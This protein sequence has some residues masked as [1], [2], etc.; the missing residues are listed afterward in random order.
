M[1]RRQNKSC[2]EG[3]E[4]QLDSFPM[5]GV[6]GNGIPQIVQNE[7]VSALVG[8]RPYLSLRNFLVD[9]VMPG[10]TGEAIRFL[11]HSMR[12]HADSQRR[13]DEGK[14]KETVKI[15]L[16][17]F[18]HRVIDHN[19]VSWARCGFSLSE[20][21]HPCLS[22]TRDQQIQAARDAMPPMKE[23]DKESSVVVFITCC[24][25]LVE[26]CRGRIKN[27]LLN[28][29]PELRLVKDN[30]DANH[31]QFHVLSG[32]GDTK[33]KRRTDKEFA[34]GS[35]R[36]VWLIGQVKGAEVWFPVSDD[37]SVPR[38]PVIRNL[39]RRNVQA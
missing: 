20:V 16:A 32:H 13:F 4:Q 5:K 35:A 2:L 9:A 34:R 15:W 33:Y 19:A 11:H 38:F 22:H 26:S 31:F 8:D 1:G 3:I 17:G 23:F 29:I 37:H 39:A 21:R 14:K 24:E 6:S 30:H 28:H 7:I 27:A 36:A 10:V 25:I 12:N 18:I